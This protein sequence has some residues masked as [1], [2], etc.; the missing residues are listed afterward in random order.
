MFETETQRY[1]RRLQ[2]TPAQCEAENIARDQLERVFN[3]PAPADLQM[4]AEIAS[5]VACADLG[6]PEQ[7][8]IEI[9]AGAHI[10]IAGFPAAGPTS[11]VIHVRLEGKCPCR[12][13]EIAA[14]EVRHRWQYV[15]EKFSEMLGRNETEPDA[16]G[17][18]GD[19]FQRFLAGRC[20]WCGR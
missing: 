17:Y 1:L 16:Y 3:L 12:V 20:R 11:H 9:P 2:R 13:A 10:G 19:F 18:D 5:A 8:V 6:I 7:R 14:H 15:T 4:V